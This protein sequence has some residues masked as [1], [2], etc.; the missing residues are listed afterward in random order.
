MEVRTRFLF[1][2]F[3]ALLIPIGPAIALEGFS[4]CH[5]AGTTVTSISGFD[6]S[7]AKM[8]SVVTLPDAIEACQRNEQLHGAALTACADKIMK[9]GDSHI[10]EVVVWANCT[11]GT[12]AVQY[13]PVP[14]SS[15]YKGPGS[16][17]VDR[18]KFP[19]FPSCGGDNAAAVAAFKTLCPSYEGKIE[20][21]E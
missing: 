7:T 2:V 10:G 21:E 19:V 20:L 8:V 4:T 14:E 12:L 3:V 18:Y 9:E 6:T 1:S 13:S 16:T 11:K 15:Y 17:H 5:A